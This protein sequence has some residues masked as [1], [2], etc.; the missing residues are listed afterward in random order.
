MFQPPLVPHD[1]AVPHF[2]RLPGLT[3]SSLVM[4]RA[5]EDYALVDA[6]RQH[7]DGT[8]GPTNPWPRETT[9]RSNQADVAWHEVEFGCRTSFA[10]WIL[11]GETAEAPLAGCVYVT[12]SPVPF[13]QCAVYFWL[14]QAQD[15]PGRAAAVQAELAR[16]LAESWDF[17][18]VAFPGRAVAW[19]NWPAG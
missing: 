1:L 12:P 18:R 5:A 6:N 13:Y 4:E 17:G 10:W 9:A 11:A 19:A 7:V 15:T 8:F 3:L 16:W 2:V 14:D